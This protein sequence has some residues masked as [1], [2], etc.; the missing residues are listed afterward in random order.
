MISTTLAPFHLAIPVDDID[1]ARKFYGGVLGFSEGR[2]DTRWIDWNFQGH[3]LVTH[4]VGDGTLAARDGVAGTNQVDG[5][6]VPVPHFGLVLSVDDFKNLAAKLEAVN[7]GFVID[8][9]V[10]FAGGP[11]GQRARIQGLREHRPV[12]HEVI[13]H[14]GRLSP[15]GGGDGRPLPPRTAPPGSL[16]TVVPTPGDWSGSHPYPANPAG[17]L[18]FSISRCRHTLKSRECGTPTQPR[19]TSHEHLR[20]GHRSGCTP[21]PPRA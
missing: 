8:P 16:T 13:S 7:T 20:R 11:G 17:P 9:Y 3:Q 15:G 19:G 21:H 18:R 2:S 1:A 14:S 4:Q 12:V 10:R 5:H 6:Q